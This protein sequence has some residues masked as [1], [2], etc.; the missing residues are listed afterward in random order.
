MNADRCAR[1]GCSAPAHFSPVLSFIAMGAPA[2]S[3]RG[4]ARLDLPLCIEHA[5]GP[6]SAFCSVQGFGQ[7]C[8]ALGRSNLPVPEFSSLQVTFRPVGETGPVRPS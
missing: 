4:Y 5:S 2:D 7:L 6:P 8:H 3:Q 1:E